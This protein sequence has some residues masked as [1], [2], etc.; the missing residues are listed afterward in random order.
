MRKKY[1][2][3]YITAVCVFLLGKSAFAGPF[4]ETIQLLE[5]STSFH[6]GRDC[7]VWIVHYPEELV[8]PW[9]EAETGRVGMTEA[10]RDAYRRNFISELS[11]G[12][13]E[14]FLFTVYAFAPRPMSFAPVSE[15]IALVTPDGERLKPVR[16]DRVLDQPI[17][18]IAQGLIFFPKREERDFAVAVRGMGVYDERI[19]SFS[20]ESA[21]EFVPTQSAQ[22]NE[23]EMVIVELPSKPAP[24]AQPKREQHRKE[25]ER[26]TPPVVPAPEPQAAAAE[27]VVVEP[28]PE[29]SMADF[30]ANLRS[31][32]KQLQDPAVQA[33][34]K[35]DPANAYV[36]RDGT[37]RTFLDLWMK[38]E[39]EAMYNMLSKAS[40]KTFSRDAFRA[41]LRKS[42]DFR[43]SLQDGY[44]VDWISTE[45][46][47]IV[48]VRRLLL[49]RTLASR[50]LGVIR[51]GTAWKILW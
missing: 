21:P 51:E 23:P 27:V 36:P 31:G 8:E 9:V 47:K 13:L 11:I 46:A 12:K 18:G 22:T 33:G 48:T 1:R 24:K 40:Q 43:A 6:W 37:L 29:E 34:D 42:A 44:T 39:A 5:N 38:N 25:A 17:N 15:K 45:R 16:Y 41:E 30:V 20:A 32:Q 7:F 14:P 19:F 2:G 28:E 50:T 4:E 3:L 26:V 49:I 35:G 10:E